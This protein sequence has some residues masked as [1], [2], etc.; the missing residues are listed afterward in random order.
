MRPARRTFHARKDRP[1]ELDSGIHQGVTRTGSLSDEALVVLARYP[2]PGFVKRRLAE[3]IGD[4]AAAELY[5]AFLSDL[6]RR[7][8]RHP[9]WTTYWAFEPAQSP[10]AEEIGRGDRAFPQE[11]R[12]LGERMA[13]AMS[14]TFAAGHSRV[15]L[16]GSDIPH[17]PLVALEDAFRLLAA[18]AELVLGPVDDG[19]YYLIGARAVPPVFAGMVWGGPEVFRATLAAAH[20]AGVEPAIVAGCYDVDDR[21]TL[22]RLRA[23]I[24]Q[25]RVEGLPSTSRVL[26]RLL[27]ME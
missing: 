13:S 14:R 26:E 1:Y 4:V 20:A 10:F 9:C 15:V 27:L 6:Q 25:G 7:V 18:G 3:T 22:E 5:R 8:S 19:G 24:V 21:A 12:D 17:V 2:R 23:D 16:I 11:G